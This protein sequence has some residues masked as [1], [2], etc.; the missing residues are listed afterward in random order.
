MRVVPF[1]DVFLKIT[2][3]VVLGLHC[4]ASF[5]L[6]RVGGHCSSYSAWASH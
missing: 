5:S 1:A 6:V 2:Y 3:L 4:C